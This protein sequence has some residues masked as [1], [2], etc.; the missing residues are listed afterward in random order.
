MSVNSGT[1]TLYSV[2]LTLPI[3]LTKNNLLETLCYNL[4]FVLSK[5]H[6]FILSNIRELNRVPNTTFYL[7]YKL[8]MVY[9]ILL[10][11]YPK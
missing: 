6:T 8:T 1:L 11:P 3:L 2:Y 9:T 5:R 4:N 7:I 10:Q